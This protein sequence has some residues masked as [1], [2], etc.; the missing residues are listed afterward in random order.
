[1]AEVDQDRSHAATPYKLQKAHERGQAAKSTVVIAA[2]SFTTAMVYLDWQGWAVWS[3]V[4]EGCRRLIAGAASTRG[5]G[6]QLTSLLSGMLTQALWLAMPFFGSLV[7]AGIVANVAQTG[8]ILS[9]E[10]LKPDW[11]RLNPVQGFKR[12]LSLQGLFV[13]LRSLLKLAFLGT[14]A[15]FSLTALAPQFYKLSSLPPGALVRLLL[16]DF[17]G[18]GLR[19]AGV[20]VLIAL[21]DLLFMKREFARKM[22]M[23]RRELKDEVKNRDGD[24]RV[25]ARIRE[26]RRELLKRS[27]ALRNTATA[28]VVITNPTHVA[29]ALR[30][31]HGEMASP[32]LVAKGR[33]VMAATMRMI[34]ARHRI[35]VVPS[36]S[37]ARALYRDLAIDQHV[38]PDL[39]APVAR[40]IVWVFSK[41]EANGRRGGPRFAGA[42]R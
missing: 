11:S 24:P 40:I 41:R 4:F 42:A 12:I 23:S 34:A 19:L 32:Q 14:V 30:Y 6:A 28:D 2:V 17:A 33:G 29:V 16:Q 31:V 1:M 15:Y 8:P 5:D 21:L 3:R 10:P 18:L 39:Y 9:A 27:S 20:L 26:L 7:L 38:R 35:P 22:R 37:L 25:R 36:P 13:L